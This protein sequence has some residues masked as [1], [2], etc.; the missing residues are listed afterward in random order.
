MGLEQFPNAYYNVSVQPTSS[1]INQGH[2]FDLNSV[3]DDY[4]N[5]DNS[6]K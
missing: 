3:P 5:N 2:G 4:L 1:T 6:N